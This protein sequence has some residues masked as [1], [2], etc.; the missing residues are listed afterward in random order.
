M[1]I[2]GDITDVVEISLQ[3]VTETVQ[4]AAQIVQTKARVSTVETATTDGRFATAQRATSLEARGG[5][6]R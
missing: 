2:N 1:P 3:D 4:N 5:C 6:R